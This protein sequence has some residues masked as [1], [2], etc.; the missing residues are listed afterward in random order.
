MQAL[1]DELKKRGLKMATAESCTGGMIAKTITDLPGSSAIFERGFITYSNR[2]KTELLAVPPELLDKH[3]AV[4]A[5]VARAMATGALEHS[6]A[7]IAV[8]C[9]GI[10]GP[11]GGTKDKPVGLVYI[12]LAG[13]MI[14]GAK[15]FEHSFKGDRDAVRTQ[16]VEAALQ[17][18]LNEL[19]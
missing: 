18:V 5:E 11:D 13:K 6:D 12:G 3:G 15:S 17:H 1:F 10:A 9:T 2:S 19:K 8:S 16:T 4:S 14:K 7:D